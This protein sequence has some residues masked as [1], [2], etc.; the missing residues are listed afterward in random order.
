MI[1]KIQA[2]NNKFIDILSSWNL[3]NG[4]I[5][6]SEKSAFTLEMEIRY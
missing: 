5:C 3:R 6:L 2:P 4:K 1:S